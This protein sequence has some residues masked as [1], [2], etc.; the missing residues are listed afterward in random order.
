MF[1]PQAFLGTADLREAIGACGC[2]CLC[3][4]GAGSGGGSGSGAER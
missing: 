1:D 3:Q 4:G 2:S